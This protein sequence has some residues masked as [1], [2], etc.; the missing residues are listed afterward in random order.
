MPIPLSATSPSAAKF[1]RL[2]SLARSVERDQTVIRFIR[3]SRANPFVGPTQHPNRPPSAEPR[4]GEL[5][6]WHE[7]SNMQ[8]RCS[9]RSESHDQQGLSPEDNSWF[10]WVPSAGLVHPLLRRQRWGFWSAPSGLPDNKNLS[11]QRYAASE[12]HHPT[13][14]DCNR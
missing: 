4:Q 1:R 7:S 14:R 10:R 9:T 8:R 5:T 12:S 13:R 6:M 11:R 3:Q 2:V